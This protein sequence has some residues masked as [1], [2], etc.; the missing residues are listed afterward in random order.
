MIYIRD[1]EYKKGERF[2]EYREHE[3]YSCSN[4]EFYLKKFVLTDDYEIFR[5]FGRV[6]LGKVTVGKDE[7]AKAIDATRI[8]KAGDDIGA[9]PDLILMK[10][11]GERNPCIFEPSFGDA[12]LDD[13]WKKHKKDIQWARAYVWTERCTLRKIADFDLD[14]WRLKMP[15]NKQK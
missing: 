3:L 15:E 4:G 5:T 8:L 7:P 1:C 6:W 13:S 11:K 12:T 2:P 10:L 14:E 9:L